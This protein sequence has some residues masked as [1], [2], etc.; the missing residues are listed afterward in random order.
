MKDLVSLII[1]LDLR[2]SLILMV[3]IY[4]KPSMLPIYFRDSMI[5]SQIV[6]TPIK[7]N[8]K[9]YPNDG[10]PLYDLIF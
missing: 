9:F 5:D 2:F 3:I 8:I 1:F 10:K 6:D 7:T 4:F